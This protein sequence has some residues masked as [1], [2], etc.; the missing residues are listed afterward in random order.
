MLETLPPDPVIILVRGPRQYGKSTRLELELQQTLREHGRGSAYF[1]N[2]DDLEDDEDLEA[3]ILALIPMFR[4]DAGVKRLFVDEISAVPNWERALKRV[5]DRGELRD[6][7]V[8]TTG[9][10]P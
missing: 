10:R 8:V 9:T 4:P 2:G 1:F 6:V 3:R 5:A 7:L